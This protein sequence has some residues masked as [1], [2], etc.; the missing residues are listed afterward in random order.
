MN[1]TDILIK[2]IKEL[3]DESK[4]NGVWESLNDEIKGAVNVLIEKLAVE[5]NDR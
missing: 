5:A 1:K 3:R 2:R 4:R